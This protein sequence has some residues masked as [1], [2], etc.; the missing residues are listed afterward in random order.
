M[1]C[2]TPGGVSDPEGY[3]ELLASGRDAIGP[4]PERWDTEALYDPDPEAAG[5]SVA[6]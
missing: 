2:R 6:R 1:A 5:K 3:W 4:F